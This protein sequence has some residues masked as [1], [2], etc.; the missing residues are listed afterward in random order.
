VA[1]ENDI[2]AEKK[3]EEKRAWFQEKDENKYREKG[4]AKQKEKRKKE[5]DS[6][7]PLLGGL[8]IDFLSV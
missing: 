8:F 3:A 7:R 4:A 1:V 5:I 6:I 2:P